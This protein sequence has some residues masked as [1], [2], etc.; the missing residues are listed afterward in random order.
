MYDGSV[1]LSNGAK[2]LREGVSSLAEGSSELSEG[3]QELYE[4]T[5]ELSDGTNELSDKTAAMDTQVTD[6]LNSVLDSLQGADEIVSF[7]SEKNTDVESVQFVIK[8]QAIE[9]SETVTEIN[10]QE[11]HL[12]FWQKLLRLFGLY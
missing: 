6:K 12:T 5:E 9:L 7:V 4:G 8:T 10:E 2:E 3:M 1:T 11:E